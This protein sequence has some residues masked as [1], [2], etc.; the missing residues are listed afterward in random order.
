MRDKYSYVFNNLF[1]PLEDI[2]FGINKI[3]LPLA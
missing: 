3:S 2:R 1:L